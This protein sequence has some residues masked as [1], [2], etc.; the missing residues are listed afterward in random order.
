MHVIVGAAAALLL[1]L[2]GLAFRPAYLSR[3]AADVDRYTHAHAL[4][5][6]LWL[7]LLIAQ[8]VL[9]GTRRLGAHRILGRLSLLAAPA[10]VLSSVLLAHQRFSRM[11]EATFAREGY[12]LYL[13]LSAAL[14]F[15]LA[16]SLAY[17]HRRTAALHGRFVFCTLLLLV[18]PVLGRVLAFHVLTLPQFW[19]YQVLTFGVEIAAV[20][21]LDLTLPPRRNLRASFRPF[22][23][24]YVA[25]L[26]LWFVFP[27]S[28]TWMTF[29]SWF[30]RLALTS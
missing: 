8:S 19:H 9:A 10:F 22:A 5:G 13:P 27:R 17:V 16:F 14:L 11:D 12:T 30:R 26:L 6:A 2:G 24:A 4:L 23:A 1:A 15:A 29:G 21:A 20:V 7:G 25:V 18:D 3:P 28:T